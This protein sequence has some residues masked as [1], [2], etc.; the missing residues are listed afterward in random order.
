MLNIFGNIRKK[1]GYLKLIT[2]MFFNGFY[3]NKLIG[4]HISFKRFFSKKNF[5][6]IGFTRIR[7]EE[8]IIDDTLKHMANFVDAILVY[9]D[10]STDE[11]LKEV[12]KNKNVVEILVNKFWK[13]DRL[14]EEAMNRQELLKAS[15]KYNPYYLFYFDADERFEGN[16]RE[17]LLNEGEKMAFDSIRIRLFD[18]YITENDKKGIKKGEKVYNFRKYFGPE[19]RDIVM[20]WKNS[21]KIFF[22]GNVAR[23]PVGIEKTI[24]K[25]RCQHYG[26]SLSIEQWEETCDFYSKNFPEPYITKWTNRKG[27]AIHAKSDFN[28]ELYLWNELTKDVILKL[29]E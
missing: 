28:R 15:Q 13:I 14:P 1:I 27:K 3:C 29:E 24:T 18:A 19:Y 26:K 21:K 6:I 8:L 12:L 9:D 17:F 23:E 10:A 7:N 4:P 20:I 11:T 2:I 22:E 5:K 16:I 25:F